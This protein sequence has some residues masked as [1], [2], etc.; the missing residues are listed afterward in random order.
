MIHIFVNRERVPNGPFPITP[1][2]L[3]EARRLYREEWNRTPDLTGVR[4]S[5][6]TTA[7]AILRDVVPGI[8]DFDAGMIGFAVSADR[9]RVELEPCECGHA[10]SMHRRQAS[11]AHACTSHGCGCSGVV[12]P[13]WA[14]N[15]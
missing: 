14:E 10:W 3:A 11:G 9:V 13:R 6:Q 12:M 5:P 8:S 2:Q 15:S 7:R 4:V 1:A